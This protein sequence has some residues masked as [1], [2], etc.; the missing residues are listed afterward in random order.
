MLE[1]LGYRP[2]VEFKEF[3]SIVYYNSKSAV[4]L[5]VI[6]FETQAIVKAA[7]H[8]FIRAIETKGDAGVYSRLQEISK[9]TD[10]LK[11]NIEDWHLQEYYISNITPRIALNNFRFEP[12][13]QK[14]LSEWE[15][16]SE[17]AGQVTEEEEAAMTGKLDLLRRSGGHDDMI[18][19][20]ERTLQRMGESRQQRNQLQ[21]KLKGA[22]S[23]LNEWIE[24]GH[25]IAL[26]WT[27]STPFHLCDMKDLKNEVDLVERE[28]HKIWT[29]SV[30]AKA[31][32]Q[33]LW[34][35]EIHEP[36]Y[37]IHAEYVGLFHPSMHELYKNHP[38]L[39]KFGKELE[40]YFNA[41]L[42]RS[43]QRTTG[44][45]EESST[46]IADPIAT[47]LRQAERVEEAP[48]KLRLKI[49]YDKIKLPIYLGLVAIAR[50]DH[51]QTASWPFVFDLNALTRHVLITGTSGS[52]KTRV[53]QLITE[54]ASLH[55][56]VVILDPVGEFTGLIYPN[57]DAG[58]ER[59]FRL[60]RGRG[61]SP[62]I[63]TLEEDGVQFQA[64]LLKKPMVTGDRL[65]SQ[66]EDIALILS[67][68]AG[69]LRFR[70]TF[71]EVLLD[72]WKKGDFTFEEFMAMCRTNAAQKRTAIKLDRLTPYK[73]L[74]SPSNFNVQDL[75]EN[76]ITI[77]TFN[78]TRFT[79]SQKLMFM[80]FI[81]RELSNYFL[82]QLHSDELE[83]LVIV[84][85]THRFYSE[86]Q[87][88]SAARVLEDL[89]AQG[90]GKGLGM[91][92][93]T[94]TIK[95]IPEIFTQADTRILLKIA[96]GEIQSYAQKFS[97]ELA[98]RLRLLDAR[99]GYVFLGPEQF[100]CKFRPTLSNPKGILTLEELR[101][102][103]AP[104]KALQASIKHLMPEGQAAEL[105]EQKLT[106]PTASNLEDSAIE[107]LRKNNGISVS[108]L[109]EILA[110]K[111]QETITN[112]VNLLE[113]K[114][115]VTTKRVANKRLIYLTAEKTPGSHTLP[116]SKEGASSEKETSSL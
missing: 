64:N 57:P 51:L 115:M 50:E 68:L 63:Y 7:K 100:Y 13:L 81:I 106:T 27:I 15:E 26:I 11:Q 4:T 112:L 47:F 95:D 30:K 94:Q 2:I 101:Q 88:S 46:A 59:E 110:L 32:Q 79:E 3:P 67:E 10:Y 53:G 5:N 43:I 69:D 28:L 116:S 1:N 105:P 37:V 72:G 91:V 38:E 113:S 86:P 25:A 96:E 19:T 78:S 17:V 18:A 58:K 20:M 107:I 74:M 83:L 92:V 84:D 90:R 31:Y 33:G 45:S 29:E 6:T 108:R 85:E 23:I 14:Y 73:P 89:N 61:Y 71:R 66:A 98:R 49:P 21:G 70:D 12:Q 52:G 75:L 56:P 80:W 93:I 35:E 55:V 97:A 103:S 41:R 8:F 39:S 54:A 82:N 40:R 34:L 77:F 22:A 36:Q 65:V 102:Y 62:I 60:G 16:K 99:E 111:S 42:Q 114:K 24:K 76:K 104:H 44:Y 109:R 87:A 9:F 48:S